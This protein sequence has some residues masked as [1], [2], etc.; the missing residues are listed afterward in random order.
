[1]WRQL[2]IVN[3]SSNVSTTT[4]GS[5]VRFTAVFT[6]A[7]QVAYTGIT[8]AADVTGILDDATADGDQTATSGTLTVTATGISWTGSIPVGG[9]VT[10]T[11]TVTV[12]NPDTGNKVMTSTFST[13]AAG[14][15][16]RGRGTDPRCST[17]SVTV[18]VPALSITQSA[19]TAA[20][21]PGQAVTYTLTITD[22]GPDPVCRRHRHR[23]AATCSTTRT[24]HNDAAATSGTLSL[25]QPGAHL[26][27][28]P[29]GRRLGGHHLHR[30]REQ[31]R[32]RR[33]AGHHHRRL[34]RGPV[35]LPARHH[36]HGL[37]LTVPVLTPALTIAKTA[38]TTTPTPGQQVTYTVTVT[39]TGQTPYTAASLTDPLAAVLDDAAY[40]KD[41]AAVVITGTGTAGAVSYA[42][43]ALS[44]TGDL[45]VGASVTITYSV[46]INYPD[47][48]DLIL[49]NTITSATAGS[50]C[51]TASGDP[52]CTVTL[53]IVNAATLTITQTAGT[54]ST[55]AGGVVQYTIT[56]AN[57][58]A[59]PYASASV[60]DPLA[61]VLDDA[62]YKG[63]A[64]AVITG[65][66]TDAGPVSF[67]S[68]NLT[69]TGTVPATGSIT[70][71]YSV[72][73]NNPDTGDQIL[74]STVSSASPDSN[75]PDGSTDPRCTATVTVSQLTISSAFSPATATPGTTINET[76]TIINTGQTPYLGIS[77]GF[78]TA[79]HRRPDQQR[80]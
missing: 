17:V 63:D 18:L 43:S 62:A 31:P 42:G 75:C 24:Y 52:R 14:S 34:G 72:T 79:E 68:P 74:S 26:D 80:R 41:A 40:N 76:T 71:T 37:P 11:G 7:G 20:A 5:V 53:T 78:T 45:A 44:W 39:D 35:Q 51:A 23:H 3:V 8:I 19:N 60:T 56:I 54:A 9:S 2:T 27:R 57:S 4:P 12:N 29:G 73:V 16:C 47:N 69:W 25:R 1:M 67:T 33:Q 36:Q 59:S 28:G 66:G 55:V 30:H 48:G 46:T 65:T 21:V 61:G 15:N 10:I 49:T 38:S 50:N 22:N 13:A 58:V 32:Y 64:T 70:I 77:V 6:N